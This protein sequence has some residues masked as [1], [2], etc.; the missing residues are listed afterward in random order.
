VPQIERQCR[1]SGEDAQPDGNALGCRFGHDEAQRRR[2]DAPVLHGG[3]HVG[4]T[5]E[6]QLVNYRSRAPYYVVD[7]L[8]GAAELRL[9]GES[10]QVVRIERTDGRRRGTFGS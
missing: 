8:F 7:R 3:S 6:S 5:G 1:V 9:G 10:Q 2:P 4:P